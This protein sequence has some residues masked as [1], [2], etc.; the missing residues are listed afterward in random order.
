M[1]REISTMLGSA[2][3]ISFMLFCLFSIERYVFLEPALEKKKQG[4]YYVFSMLAAIVSNLLF[5]NDIGHF[6]IV[7]VVGLNIALARRRKKF[8][9]FLLAIPIMGI[10]NGLVVPVLMLPSMML[11]FS[12]DGH[13][14]Y[15]L[16]FY[17]V[18]YVFL[19]VFYVK[20]KALR[21]NFAEEMGNRS[22][23]GWEKTLLWAVGFLMTIYSGIMSEGSEKLLRDS[24]AKSDSE[25]LQLLL[26]GI[27]AF[28]LTITVIVL[29][30]QGN[31]RNYYHQKAMRTQ[32]V[33]LEKQKN[34][35]ANEMKS[36][37]LSNVSHEI[38]TPMNAI[39]G[40]TEILLRGE[41]SPQTREYLQNIKNSGGALLTIINDLLD[42]SK[43]EAGK[44][45]I[46]EREYEPMSLLNDVSMIFLNRIG[47]KNIELLYDV[48]KNM[49][50][51]LYGDEH[52]IRQ[53]MINLVN[54]AIKFTK[55]GYV[56]L[57]IKTERQAEG[58]VKMTCFVKDTGV[59]IKEDQIGRL[60]GS[61]EQVD[62]K[63]NQG[64]EG[65]GLGLSISK[66]LVELMGGTIGVESTYGEGSTFYF[67]VMQGI[68]EDSPAV[69]LGE[70]AKN[71][72][73]ALSI[74]NPLLKPEI[75][76]LCESYGVAGVDA[77][78]ASVLGFD[79]FLTDCA[80][81]ITEEVKTLAQKHKGSIVL[82]QNP[83]IEH[84]EEAS[85]SIINK[86]FYSLNFC[87]MLNQNHTQPDITEENF[88]YTA[89]DARILIVD[90]NDM[91]LKVARG[92]LE[93]MK[94]HIDVAHNG[95]EAVEK[96]MK[97]HY[98]MVLMDHMMPVMD[99]VEA[100]KAIR[101]LPGEEYANLPIIALSANATPMAKE[102]FLKEK[103]NDFVAKPIKMKALFC[104]MIKWLPKELLRSN[105]MQEEE[106]TIVQQNLPE[107]ISAIEGLDI[108][109]G[110]ENCGSKELF[111]ELV[112]DF[113]KN[114]E[115]EA[116]NLEIY[117]SNGQIEEYTIRVH[118]LK[119]TARMVGAM[120]LSEHF[121]AMEHLGRAKDVETVKE[122]TPYV[123]QLYR[124][125]IEKLA[126]YVISAENDD[127]QQGTH[128]VTEGTAKEEHVAEVKG[129][130][131]ANEKKPLI[132]LVDDDVLSSRVV[133][134]M[135]REEF[136]VM[137]ARSGKDALKQ[138]ES[139]IPELI[140]LDVHM[141]E[142]SGHDVIHALKENPKYADIPVIFLTSDEDEKTEVQGFSEGAIDFLKKPF[143]KGVSLQRIRRILELS[144]LQKHLKQEV[145]KQTAVA[146][147]R[148]E[149]VERIS[150]QMI[151]ALANTIDAKDSYTNGHST[152][153]AKYSVKIAER[154]GY[155]GE[156]LEHLQY[157]ALLHDIGKIGIPN[158]IINKTSRLTDEEY[159]IIKTHPGIGGKILE[160]ISE[161]SDIS[162][163]AR[164]HHERF[165]GRGYPD[166]LVGTDIPE[167]ARIIGVADAYDAMTSNRSYRDI[168]PQDVVMGEI[169]KGKASQFDPD[170]A[171]VMIQLMKEDRDYEMHE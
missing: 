16:V 81:S 46:I 38:R 160:Q 82:L 141:P 69:S 73:I 135:L 8:P 19:A 161:I 57:Q 1:L 117:L 104:C 60:F 118:A 91:N 125:Y 39:V 129:K 77:V 116:K 6:V 85:F 142:L 100:T 97:Q 121:Y 4:M 31:K 17:G 103:M 168:L 34:E 166:A 90:D 128:T 126:P 167:M 144:Y 165:D 70:K 92:L 124:S 26:M 93:V 66:Q 157:A 139:Y 48:D 111:M 63:K 80:D 149:R 108:K 106:T 35:A 7:L 132:M 25:L 140:L 148:R 145:R 56:K 115:Q 41:H 10:G 61:F 50:A 170:I 36:Q 20:G 114:I 44:M 113:Q 11:R 42:F 112:S 130:T 49:P 67:S 40:M 78:E 134:A 54:N 43:I 65:T 12:E 164:W 162:I 98:D 107:G 99:G 68:V 52:R 153:V 122:R 14:V 64:I 33:I 47:E 55:S 3:E 123:L 75:Q 131:H 45:E 163:G 15:S 83:M 119:N 152:R 79:Y 101:E 88:S 84:Q 22:L 109:E 156:K 76:K 133:I 86:P 138:L 59:G 28:V 24:N 18:I 21:D 147:K 151:Q 51:R 27:V 13:M 158:E 94:M 5:G 120:E 89:P 96:V 136:R 159:E 171:E 154:M 137:P 2:M 58:K 87:Q 155:S 71:R 143:R 29:V 32:K 127:L 146:E 9:G 105:T 150:L 62:T 102:L 95:K 30:V 169:E 37:F 53:V 110:L 74:S 72:T 23:E